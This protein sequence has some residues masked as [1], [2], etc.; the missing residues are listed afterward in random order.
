MCYIYILSIL[1]VFVFVFAF[2]L[3]KKNIENFNIYPSYNE[4]KK[5][6][7]QLPIVGIVS[8]LKNP[9]NLDFWIKYHQ[10]IGIDY[11]YL[12]DDDSSSVIINNTDDRIKR[13]VY[14]DDYLED[15]KNCSLV[16]KYGQYYKK[17]VM[18]RQV[19]NTQIALKKAKEDKVDWLLHIDGDELLYFPKSDKGYENI[20]TRLQNVPDD[21]DWFLIKNNEVIINNSVDNCFTDLVYFK[22][23]NGSKL[24]KAYGNGKGLTK[25]KDG[26]EPAGVHEFYNSKIEKD[27]HFIMAD[28]FILHYPSCRFNEWKKK[29]ENLGYFPDK[30][31]NQPNNNKVFDSH[32][33]S[34]DIRNDSL[35][36]KKKFYQKEFVLNQE[37]IDILIGKNM[38]E[39]I[40]VTEW[41]E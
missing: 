12:F 4:F 33:K 29:Y 35:E 41:I 2:I 39:K 38:A 31:W 34:R 37:E 7:N 23:Q 40:K 22:N 15:L 17:E 6:K 9:H 13:I 20:Q 5:I 27:R 11:F 18:S 30:Y 32:A 8:T 24:Y 3:R 16:N 28:T 25:V 14:N 1:V 10:N 36:N 26:M 21:V 19:L